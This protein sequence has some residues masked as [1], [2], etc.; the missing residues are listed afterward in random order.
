MARSPYFP[1]LIWLVPAGFLLYLFLR[2][3]QGWYPMALDIV[4][5]VYYPWL[6]ERY[7]GLATWTPVHN[8]YIS[9]VTSQAIVWRQFVA[10][11]LQTFQSFFWH[12]YSLSGYPYLGSAYLTPLLHPSLLFLFMR[13]VALGIAIGTLMQLVALFAA[14]IFFFRAHKLDP[15]A[16]V[17]GALAITLGGQVATWF[18]LGALSYVLAGLLVALGLLSAGQ[19]RYLPL[20]IFLTVC[21]GHY[22]YVIYALVIILGY[23][24]WVRAAASTVV[25]LL[26]G[27]GMAALILIP[28]YRVYQ[29]SI[30]ESDQFLAT[31]QQGLISPKHLVTLLTPD[32]FGNPATYNYSGEEDYQEK[33]GYMGAILI[34]AALLSLWYLRRD[35]RL[36]FFALLTGLAGLCMVK[37][38]FSEWLLRQ[39]L[40]LLGNSKGS[41]PLAIFG[42]GLATLSTYGLARAART[43]RLALYLGLGMLLLSGALL[44]LT[45]PTWN[46]P[47]LLA[48]VRVPPVRDQLGAA[49]VIAFR[50]A[51]LSSLSLAA[52][53]LSLLLAARFRRFPLML[54]LA[55][56]LLADLGRYFL[57]YNTLARRELYYPTT[58]E[59]AFLQAKQAET[60]QP[61]RVEYYGTANVPMNIWEAYHLE[62]ASG[63]TSIYPKRYGEFIGIV[64]DDKVNPRPGRFVHV[65]RPQSPLFDLLN[66]RYV[67]VN[68]TDCPDGNGN[69]IVCQVVGD[70][71][72]QL[73]FA[74]HNMAIYENTHAAPRFFFPASVEVV[75]DPKQLVAKLSSP[76]YRPSHLLLEQDPGGSLGVGEPG[77]V[78]LE[79]Y[80]AARVSLSVTTPRD[81]LLVVGNTYD[82]GWQATLDGQPVP[83]YR[84]NYALMAV[85]IGAG[86]HQL[87]M[88]YLPPGLTVGSMISAGMVSLYGAYLWY[89][90]RPRQDQKR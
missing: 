7:L 88:R 66:I 14:A 52:A 51:L 4:T 20:A 16:A 84:A 33:S 50:S 25:S 41:R 53:G 32:Y 57:K 59:W 54:F 69:N 61:F 78:Q 64:N 39:P 58:P 79:S 40:P 72:Y 83:I 5:G 62:S 1:R 87:V 47:Q 21:G 36:L 42:L 44:A 60:D 80:Q 13:P 43:P 31:R 81:N 77:T 18:E 34:P 3:W 38:P 70:P 45:A 6:N 29:T 63:Y 22:Q 89:T 15:A 75:S 76:T 37:N 35:R 24:V 10:E 49:G 65:F 2:L 82:P 28:T 85:P 23:G 8:P 27:V 19:R 68:H 73:V 30:R 74:R 67:L 90:R 56:I 9:D 86:T 12:N 17:V 48:I 26:L 11:H 46:L 71:K 55:V